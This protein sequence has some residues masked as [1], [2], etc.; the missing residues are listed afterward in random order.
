MQVA[1]VDAEDR[2]QPLEGAE[3]ALYPADDFGQL[4]AAADPIKLIPIEGTS[5]SEDAGNILG[6]TLEQGG[7][8]YLVETK[9]SHSR[10]LAPS[11]LY[12]PA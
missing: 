11:F 10:H 2:S 9:A 12:E 1:K 3:F 7:V 4:N 5:A 6:A 8:Y